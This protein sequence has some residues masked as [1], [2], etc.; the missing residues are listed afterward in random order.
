M[1]YFLLS[2]FFGKFSYHILYFNLDKKG[3]D[4][5]V[6]EEMYYS[7]FSMILIFLSLFSI[8]LGGEMTEKNFTQKI[9]FFKLTS[10][11][12]QILQGFFSLGHANLDP[13]LSFILFINVDEALLKNRTL[14]N[15]FLF[16]ETIKVNDKAQNYVH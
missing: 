8:T 9:V 1:T 15:R 14:F 7:N 13:P 4:M 11:L 12:T 10:A 2:F 6:R 3:K 5:F 16:Q